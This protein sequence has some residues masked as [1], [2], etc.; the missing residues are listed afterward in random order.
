MTRSACAPAARKWPT[1][2]QV[3]I[4]VDTPGWFDTFGRELAGLSDG[5]FL[6]DVRQVPEQAVAFYLSCLQL[7][8]P[9][10]LERAWLNVVVHA[11]DLP[12][13]RG[14]S[15]LAWQVLEGRTEIPITMIEA[16]PEADAGNILMRDRI[17]LEG[18]EL[19]GEM[20]AHLGQKVVE[21]CLALLN[22]PAVPAGCPQSGEGS[23]Y[24][25]RR[26]QD[27]RI[28]PDK[29]VA[30]QFDLLRVVDNDRYP[31][32]IDIR[33]HRYILKIEKAS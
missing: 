22:Q 23:W 10:I 28:D 5:I 11:S 27:S 18:H 2:R 16:T 30:E 7:T 15:P 4:V 29:T 31:A 17:V 25:R 12:Y 26:P 19:N 14:F 32:F 21:M 8:P 9:D 3:A 6:R 24:R 1:P 20:R 33:D 13:G